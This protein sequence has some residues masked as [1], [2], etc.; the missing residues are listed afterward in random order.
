MLL[1]ILTL[2]APATVWRCYEE[3]FALAADGPRVFAGTDGGVLGRQEDGNWLQVG[4]DCP[5]DVRELK[6]TSVGLLARVGDGRV[7]LFTTSGW[8]RNGTGALQN[9]PLSFEAPKGS[10]G[11]RLTAVSSDGLYSFWN[12]K[13]YY[14]RSADGWSEVGPRPP[15]PLDYCV[16]RV[17]KELLAGT[18]QGLWKF[19]GDWKRVPLPS[20][21]PISGRI[22]GIAGFDNKFLVGGSSGIYVGRPGDW[23]LVN[24]TRVRQIVREG[25]SAWVVYG[26][27]AVDKIVPRLDRL[28]D[29]VLYGGAKR[30]WTGAMALGDG[31]ALFGGHGGWIEKSAKGISE[32]YMDELKGDVVT[33]IL[34][35]ERLRWIGTQKSGLVRYSGNGKPLVWNPGNGLSDTWV[36]ALAGTSRGIIVGTASKG[37]F[38]QKSFSIEPFPGPTQM[39]RCLLQYKN[40]VVVGGM[41]GAWIE[42]G[43]GW[44]KLDTNGEETTSLSTDGRLIVTTNRG[45]FF[46]SP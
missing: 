21:L 13:Y 11:T 27:G 42:D 32:R 16:L 37:L 28:Y 31:V 43:A 41:D 10:G 14:R 38:L 29:D 8:K 44:T 12:A 23:K 17:G 2:A 39:V 7:F 15:T 36:T 34:A 35:R 46:L 45:V 6:V 26:S 40:R 3:V 5:S 25:D 24:K 33:A 4:A 1:A 9:P 30:P 18:Q 19:D 22:E 20:R